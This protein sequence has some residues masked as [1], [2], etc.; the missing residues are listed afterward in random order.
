MSVEVGGLSVCRGGWTE[1]LY[2]WV[3]SVSVEVGRLS[4]CRSGWT[5]CV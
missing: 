2:R 4:V 3:D 5:Q 1:C